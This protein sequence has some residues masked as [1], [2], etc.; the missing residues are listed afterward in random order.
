M[1]EEKWQCRLGLRLRRLAGAAVTKLRELPPAEIRQRLG[2]PP[3]F[4][5]FA[6][7]SHCVVRGSL[8]VSGL[9]PLRLRLLRYR[10]RA[11]SAFRSVSLQGFELVP[12]S[13]VPCCRHLRKSLFFQRRLLYDVRFHDVARFDGAYFQG[14]ATFDR[15]EAGF[16]IGLTGILANGNFSIAEA[17]LGAPAR[18][19]GAVM[20]GGFWRL[21][22]PAGKTCRARA[23]HDLRAPV[24]VA[25]LAAGR[26]SSVDRLDRFQ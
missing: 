24:T 15:C 17:Q 11:G 6:D 3:A 13:T 19:A 21:G 22:N 7:L 4:G 20:M 16:G 8:N 2:E 5:R 10:V 9:K 18:L 26:L 12:R 1:A 23:K 14:I 25:A